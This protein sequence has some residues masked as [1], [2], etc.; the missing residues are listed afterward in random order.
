[1]SANNDR[2]VYFITFNIMLEFRFVII[3]E[4]S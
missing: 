3:K 1:M 4:T 2:R